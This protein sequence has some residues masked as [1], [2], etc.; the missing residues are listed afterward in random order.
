MFSLYLS[1][2]LSLCS[3]FSHFVGVIGHLACFSMGS[4]LWSFGHKQAALCD[5][6]E[7][8]G[9]T[10]AAIAVKLTPN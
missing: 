7:Y 5:F 10:V 8:L 4:G 6:S 9:I 1:L 2:S 3:V